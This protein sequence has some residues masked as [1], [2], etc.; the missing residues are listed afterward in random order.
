MRARSKIK[1][2][3]I[4]L[5]GGGGAIV[6][7]EKRSNL[8]ERERKKKE[9][10]RADRGMCDNFSQQVPL[11]SPAHRGGPPSRRT[12]TLPHMDV[13][14]R[15]QTHGP[16]VHPLLCIQMAQELCSS[17]PLRGFSKPDCG[18]RVL[19][20]ALSTGAFFFYPPANILFI[21]V[22]EPTLF[23]VARLRTRALVVMDKTSFY[24]AIYICRFYIIVQTR[25]L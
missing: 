25:C 18:D 1:V 23:R 8:C 4:S 6:V 3:P 13:R 2:L 12:R 24:A 22:L 10:K 16:L 20:R 15:T 5:G 11:F 14:A 7:E 21:R 9:K 17:R 19:Q